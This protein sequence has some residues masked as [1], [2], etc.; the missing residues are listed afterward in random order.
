G[1]V[2][3]PSACPGITRVCGTP[4]DE[5]NQCAEGERCRANGECELTLCDEP[6][7][8]ACPASMY[9]HP[10]LAAMVVSSAVDGVE[11]QPSFAQGR[12]RGCVVTA[13]DEPGGVV[14]Q[15]S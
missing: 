7:A 5:D 1:T 12:K 6:E 15:N 13:C 9:C 14:C 4:C 10:E 2:W 8:P 3:D 11:F